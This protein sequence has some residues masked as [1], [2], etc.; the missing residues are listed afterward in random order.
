MSETY[1]MRGWVWP[2]VRTT[3]NQRQLQEMIALSPSYGP[4]DDF[5]SGVWTVFGE[6]MGV[7]KRQV[8]EALTP[9]R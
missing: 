9:L 1:T 6:E 4:I 7:S 5:L 2:S 8:M 3:H